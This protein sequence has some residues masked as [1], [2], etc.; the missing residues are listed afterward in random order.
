M[1]IFTRPWTPDDY[2]LSEQMQSYWINFATK[3]DPNGTGLPVW[4]SFNK[5]NCMIMDLN[6]KSSAY[7]YPTSEGMDVLFQ[8][9]TSK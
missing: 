7:K 6:V 5:D 1:K 8:A 9:A 2:K 3:G 4:P